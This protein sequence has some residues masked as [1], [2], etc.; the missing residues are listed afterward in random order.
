M[1]RFFCVFMLM[2]LIGQRCKNNELPK[3][4]DSLLKRDEML[5]VLIVRF[6]VCDICYVHHC[7]DTRWTHQG[8]RVKDQPYKQT[9]QNSKENTN[10]SQSYTGWCRFT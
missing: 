3:W 2:Q 10:A 1:D 6:S 8:R 4:K 9:N 5:F 7:N